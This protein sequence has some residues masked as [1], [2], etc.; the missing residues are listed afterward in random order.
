MIRNLKTLGLA[1]VAVLA[2]SAMA[3][4]AANAQ[5]EDAEL[6]AEE[7][8]VTLDGTQEGLQVLTRDGRTVSCSTANFHSLA[9]T[10]DTTMD[11]APTY[12]GCVS[13]INSPATVTMNGCE[14]RFHLK[15]DTINHG[16][17]NITS[18]YTAEAQLICPP[19]QKVQIHVYSSHTNHTNNVNLCTYEFGAQTVD[20]TIDLTNEDPVIHN[21][22]EE[23]E[24]VTTPKDWIRAH[25]DVEGITSTRTTGGALLCGIEHDSAGS[26]HGIAILKGTNLEEEDNGITISTDAG[27]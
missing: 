7:S 24:E 27:V 16:G 9:D 15:K 20:G 8:P 5:L 18:T 11:I 21:P 13:N 25:I 12:A 6:T 3:A 26:L 14:Y 19:N 17:G 23:D 1:L 4:S 22:G 2:M 10:G